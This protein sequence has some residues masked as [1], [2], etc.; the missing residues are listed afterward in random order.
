MQHADAN[1]DLRETV[2]TIRQVAGIVGA[3]CTVF[4]LFL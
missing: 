3:I 4:L 1:T 2:W